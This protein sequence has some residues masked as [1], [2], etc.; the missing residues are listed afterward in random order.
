MRDEAKDHWEGNGAIYVH[1]GKRYGTTIIDGKVGIGCLGEVQKPSETPPN[2]SKGACAKIVNGNGLTDNIQVQ[3]NPIYATRG[4][5]RKEGEVHRTT[6]YRR[7]IK[8]IGKQ[9]V[10]L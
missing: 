5:P 7:N 2:G 4:R 10:L 1:Y 3:T 8:E 9:G 6:L